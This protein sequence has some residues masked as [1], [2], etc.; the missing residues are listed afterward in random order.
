MIKYTFLFTLIMMLGF[1]CSDDTLT[2]EEQFD[3]DVSLIEQYLVDNN[4]TAQK[5]SEG[6]YYI[7][8]VEGSVEKP[9][10]TSSVRCKY[11]G[12][13]LDKTIFDAND[14]STFPLYSVIQGWQIGIPKFGRGG[15][16]TILIPSKYA[17]G[18]GGSPGRTNAVLIFDIEVKDF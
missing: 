10:L 16:G 2:I 14:N 12:Y 18:T 11:A 17:Y 3:L 9:K 8:D 15:V 1:S 4:L 7:I 13:F 5:T 6:V